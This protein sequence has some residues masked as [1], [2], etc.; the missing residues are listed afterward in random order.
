MDVDL[1][2]ILKPVTLARRHLLEGEDDV[3][4]LPALFNPEGL[5]AAQGTDISDEDLAAARA[6]MW[7]NLG[8]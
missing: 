6:A 7:S 3:E 1:K 8:Q 4:A 5:W 2:Q